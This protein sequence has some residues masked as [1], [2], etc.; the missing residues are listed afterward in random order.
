MLKKTG[1]CEKP[2][3]EANK[4]VAEVLEQQ[5]RPEF[6]RKRKA[7]VYSSE[8]RAKIGKYASVNGMTMDY[9]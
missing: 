8:T 3:E 1:I 4:R 9:T 2:T 6:T 5:Q 7:T